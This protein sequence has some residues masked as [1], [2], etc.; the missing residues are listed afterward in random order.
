[1]TTT[2]TILI[3]D[4]NPD[5]IE[6]A[7]RILAKSGRDVRVEEARRGEAALEL[8]HDGKERPSLILLDLKM[9][10]MNGIDTLRKIRSDEKLKN[11][12]VVILTSSSLESDRNE[13]FD[14]GADAFV[15]KA[16]DINQ[17]S[18]D[19]KCILDRWLAN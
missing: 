16:F 15:H 18:E 13:A 12:P 17:F 4:D 14:A 1:M 9:P 3:V 5:D 6:I 2:H 8:L 7:R 19:I 10:G 11:I